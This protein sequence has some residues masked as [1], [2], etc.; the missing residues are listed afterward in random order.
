[1]T[2]DQ[3]K[4]SH[5]GGDTKFVRKYETVYIFQCILC[6]RKTQIMTEMIREPEKKKN[7]R[8]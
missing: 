2:R 6:R 5:C 8:K 4:C 3:V 1:M 7:E